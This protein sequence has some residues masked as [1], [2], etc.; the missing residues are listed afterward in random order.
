MALQD[1]IHLRLGGIY[2]DLT[3]GLRSEMDGG[4]LWINN[5]NVKKVLGLFYRNPSEKFRQYLI[6]IRDKLDLIL[7]RRCSS[8]SCDVIYRQ[9]GMLRRDVGLALEYIPADA[10]CRLV[11]HDRHA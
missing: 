3:G 5:I 10:P 9:A 7:S 6:G 1:K 8:S 11:A 2:D 4:E